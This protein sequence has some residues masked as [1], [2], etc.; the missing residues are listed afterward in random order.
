VT[1]KANGY[2]RINFE[3]LL[4]RGTDTGFGD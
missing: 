4:S 3:D 1:L 2:A